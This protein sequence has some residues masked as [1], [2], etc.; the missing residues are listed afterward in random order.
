[1]KKSLDEMTLEEVIEL[2]CPTANKILGYEIKIADKIPSYPIPDNK[3]KE[4]VLRI[5]VIKDVSYKSFI[6]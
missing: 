5:K 6:L 4:E 1:M 2:L 3:E